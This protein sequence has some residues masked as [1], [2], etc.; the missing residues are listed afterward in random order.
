MMEWLSC[1]HHK[2]AKVKSGMVE[3]APV[4]YFWAL[5]HGRT[6]MKAVKKGC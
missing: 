2:A 1:G 3:V 6:L 4:C 5:I